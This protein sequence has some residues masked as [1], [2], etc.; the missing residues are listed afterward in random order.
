MRGSWLRSPV[1]Q[2][3]RMILVYLGISHE[4]LDDL[5]N[6]GFEDPS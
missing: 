4:I 3:Q 5:W 2:I 1:N 6:H